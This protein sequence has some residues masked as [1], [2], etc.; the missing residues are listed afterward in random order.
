MELLQNL[1]GP[2]GLFT[3]KLQEH[4][5]GTEDAYQEAVD[6]YG[7]EPFCYDPELFT[8]EGLEDLADS[9]T[10]EDDDDDGGRYDESGQYNCGRSICVLCH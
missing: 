4:K 10:S 7:R 3:A 5:L 8:A 1:E 2:I 9:D 6:V